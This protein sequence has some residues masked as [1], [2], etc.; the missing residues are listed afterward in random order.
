[1]MPLKISRIIHHPAQMHQPLLLICV[2][3][4]PPRQTSPPLQASS[5][6]PTSLDRGDDPCSS[7]SACR[8]LPF[9]PAA[10]SKFGQYWSSRIRYPHNIYHNHSS[11]AP[12]TAHRSRTGLSLP[13]PSAQRSARLA[14]LLNQF[15]QIK[16]VT[17]PLSSAR[18]SQ[19]RH[20]RAFL[21]ALARI[22]S[23]LSAE[24]DL[25]DTCCHFLEGSWT[26]TAISPPRYK[27]RLR[28]L[29]AAR[30]PQQSPRI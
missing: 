15:V 27:A 13:K 21:V 26:A 22:S 23:I 16:A 20:I 14:V 5:P 3:S 30:S 8:L 17:T 9:A 1:M 7:S 4:S 25:T 18:S 2:S 28:I 24:A 11:P 6:Q 29:P 12:P 19:S 10:S